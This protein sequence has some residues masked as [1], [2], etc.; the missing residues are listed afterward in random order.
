LVIH[1]SATIQKVIRRYLLSEL[2]DI[3]LTEAHSSED[4]SE[5]I[6]DREFDVIICGK[7]I[8]DLDGLELFERARASSTN[9]NAPFVLI[10][11]DSRLESLEMVRAN[12]VEHVLVIP[13]SSRALAEKVQSL[14]NP[15]R[16]RK[17]DRVCMLGMHASFHING[18]DLRGEVINVSCGGLLC[19]LDATDRVYELLKNPDVCLHIP[20]EFGGNDLETES[21]FVRLSVLDWKTPHVP[22]RYRTAWSFRHLSGESFNQLQDAIA[23]AQSTMKLSVSQGG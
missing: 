10:T 4:G 8:E 12:G 1:H 18:G 6:H 23:R 19:D 14:C 13:F 2:T 5:L 22:A 3:D 7:E 17:Y 20:V 21:Q 9:G 15:R 11:S 16:W